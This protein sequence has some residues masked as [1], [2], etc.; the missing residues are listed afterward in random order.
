MGSI[1]ICD[2]LHEP[3][4]GMWVGEA[5]GKSKQ[6]INVSWHNL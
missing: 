2:A 6:Q 3:T 5:V 4:N 1:V